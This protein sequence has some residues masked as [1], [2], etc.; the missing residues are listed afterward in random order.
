[1]PDAPGCQ[2]RL[3]SVLCGEPVW[4]P[5]AF[6]LNTIKFNED[7]TG[8]LAFRWGVNNFIIAEIEWAFAG[9]KSAEL[10]VDTRAP[11]R[12]TALAEFEL[13]IT[14]TKRRPA[15]YLAGWDVS[16]EKLNEHYL[17]D[18]AFADKTYTVRLESGVFEADDTSSSS[19]VY[20]PG[21]GLTPPRYGLRL[22]FDQS[23][24]PPADEWR[25]D[26]RTA[27]ANIAKSWD[28]TT[29]CARKIPE[30]EGWGLLKCV[31]L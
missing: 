8:L 19:A 28:W 16:R 6:D 14:L 20:P 17:E 26:R 21:C 1:M 27:A 31:A 4:H 18:A 9:L 29:F 25:A 30:S 23:P 12:Q 15:R 11:T 5:H 7:G 24:Y 13:D 22:V 10:L 2:E 3:V